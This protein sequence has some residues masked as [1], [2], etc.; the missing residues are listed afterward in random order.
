LYKY[1]TDA[2]FFSTFRHSTDL[3]TAQETNT[4]EQDGSNLAPFLH[5]L[6]SNYPSTFEKIINFIQPALPEIGRLIAPLRGTNTE[7]AFFYMN[8]NYRIR[9][10][11]MGGGVEQLLL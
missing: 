5:T 11:D 2:F 3:L 6:M 4:L 1:L 9:L 8:G 10:H 7:V